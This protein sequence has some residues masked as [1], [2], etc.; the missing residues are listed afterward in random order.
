M[1]VWGYITAVLL[2]AGAFFAG[3]ASHRFDAARSEVRRDTVTVFDTLV[4]EIPAPHPVEVVRVDTCY[5]PGTVDTIRIP[6]AIPIE[7]KTYTTPDYRAVVEG[8]RPALVEMEV[9]RQTNIVTVTPTSAKPKR[10]GVGLQIGYGY[11]PTANR[12]TPYIGIGI[13]Y[14]LWSW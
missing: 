6:V 14:D 10:W 11:M 12:V 4:W 8:Y 13:Q 7:R 9:Y 3:R 2:F 5:L 1:K